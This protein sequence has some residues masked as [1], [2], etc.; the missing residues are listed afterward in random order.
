MMTTKPVGLYL[1]TPFCV[2]KCNY[3]DFCSFP[4][5]SV[6]SSQRA[7]YI[8][9]LVAEITGY[10]REPKIAVDT[11]FFGGGTPSLLAPSE[12]ERIFA[13]IGEAFE[14]TPDAEITI[15]AN[16]KTLSRG[17][18]ELYRNLGI[19]RLSIGLQSIHKNEQKSLGRVHNY[20]D[21]IDNFKL[22]RASGFDNISVDLMYG[23]PEQTIASFT[24]TLDAVIALSPEHVSAYGLIIEEGTPFFKMKESLP[25]PTEDAEC[26]MYRL[27]SE[28]LSA[29]GYSHY[30]ISNYARA[31][32]ESRHNLHYWRLDEYIGVGVAAHSFFDGRRYSN[33]DSLSEYTADARIYAEDVDDREF[34]YA[35]LAFR[36]ADGLSLSDFETKF[37]H[38]FTD[39]REELIA[40]YVDLGY[41][42]RDGDRLALTDSGM[43]VSNAILSELL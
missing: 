42:R 8:D 29:A 13:A 11:V 17:K 22:A 12:I 25:I 7:E 3:C 33:P 31:G 35:M 39:D 18:L 5:E 26:D 40:R 16:P 15:E 27:A 30:E 1:H 43:Y 21:F 38:A 6:S 36:L 14:I 9:T 37:S 24:E 10:K 41:M 19:N 34:E 32:R 23:I 28:K 2:R 4:E 20:T